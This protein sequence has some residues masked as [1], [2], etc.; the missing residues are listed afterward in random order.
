MS[1]L[2]VRTWKFHK[3]HKL[4]SS[5]Y[6]ADETLQVTFLSSHAVAAVL[7]HTSP[8]RDLLHLKWKKLTQ[9]TRQQLCC[10]YLQTS[11]L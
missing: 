2:P 8:W 4:R 11:T 9:R 7:L 6:V 1:V 5:V 10:Q 3:S